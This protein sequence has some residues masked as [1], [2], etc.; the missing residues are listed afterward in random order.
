M[1]AYF[2]TAKATLPSSDLYNST[3]RGFPDV[4]AQG[5]NYVVINNGKTNPAVA[6]MSY[7]NA[8]FE[9]WMKLY[10]SII[11]TTSTL[12]PSCT[13]TTVY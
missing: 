13:L 8:C 6:G 4:S 11:H 5:T 9:E 10:T 12:H 1:E 7:V 2:N 3:G